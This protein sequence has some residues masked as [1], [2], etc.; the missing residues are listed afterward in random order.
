MSVRPS[1]LRPGSSMLMLSSFPSATVTRLSLPGRPRLKP[2]VD[3]LICNVNNHPPDFTGPAITGLLGW[4]APSS[5]RVTNRAPRLLQ[6]VG[7]AQSTS[8]RSGDAH[9]TPRCPPGRPPSTC[10]V[11]DAA[12]A[13]S[14]QD[15]PRHHRPTRVRDDGILPAL[16][17][18]AI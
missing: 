13:V 18:F 15:H 12:G 17:R 8:G 6:L 1:P 16:A 10:A 11:A 4:R 9:Q 2:Q 3:H 14:C 7:A 5:P